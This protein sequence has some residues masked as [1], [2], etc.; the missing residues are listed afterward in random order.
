MYYVCF[1]GNAAM[2]SVAVNVTQVLLWAPFYILSMTIPFCEGMC[3]DPAVW[4]L[5]VWLG[6]ATAGACPALCFLD[7]HVRAQIKDMMTCQK[8]APDLCCQGDKCGGGGATKW[9]FDD[10]LSVFKPYLHLK[11]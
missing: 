1:A 5:C 6:Y 10:G 2:T 7:S 3:V 4:S 11:E 8:G 9:R